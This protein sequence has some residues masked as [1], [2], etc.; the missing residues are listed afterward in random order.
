MT[1]NT[2]TAQL[3]RFPNVTSVGNPFQM[4]GFGILLVFLFILFSRTF[5]VVLSSLQIPFTISCLVLAATVF[6]G[7][8][9]RVWD[10]KIGRYFVAFTAWMAIAIP[11]SFWRG[12]STVVFQGWLKAVLVYI[13]IVGLIATYDQT[14]RAIKVLGFAVLTLAILA[15]TLGNSE[16]G[17]LFLSEGKFQNP[18]DLAQIML[19]G[20]PFLWLM[21][22]DST[23]NVLFKTFPFLLSGLIFYVLLKTGSRGAIFGFLAM[24]LFAFIRSSMTGRIAMLGFSLILMLAAI[25]VV[26]GSLRHR[27]ATLFSSDSDGDLSADAKELADIAVASSEAR[28]RVFKKSIEMTL[29]HPLLGVGPGMF[30]EAV[31]DDLAQ[32]GKRTTFLLSHNSYTQVSSEM[33]FPGLFLYVAII[34]GCFKA[35][36]AVEKVSRVRAGP[37]WKNISSTADCLRM[38]LVAYA[39]TAIFSSVAYQSL[40]PAIAGLCTVLYT[41]VQH[42]LAQE[43]ASVPLPFEPVTKALRPMPATPRLQNVAG[44]RI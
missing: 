14:V 16:N 31:E 25:V 17:R 43:S 13:C 33:G 19:I 9:L 42:E 35:T 38:T 22:K 5:D 1:P 41:S 32:E 30:A 7:G 20:L 12:G 39:V 24:M 18:N 36:A 28:Q 27:Y 8:I 26:P 29:R 15:L 4:I 44:Q 3:Q 21:V 11:F 37:R 40:L 23:Q 2:N 10:H 34:Y 6:G